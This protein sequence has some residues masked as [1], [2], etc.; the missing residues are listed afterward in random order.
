VKTWMRGAWLLALL[1]LATLVGACGSSGDSS[2]TT[3]GSSSA[4]SAESTGVAGSL[5]D[6]PRDTERLCGDK[7]Y[8][9]AHVDGFGGNSWRKI[10]RAELVDELRACPNVTVDYT[11]AGGDIQ[12]YNTAINSYVARGY[13]AI[14]TF[15]DFGPQALPALRKAYRA[16]VVV[17][18]YNAETGGKPG[19]DYTAEVRYDK[20][21]VGKQWADWLN[22][23]LNERGGILFMGGIPGNLGSQTLMDNTTKHLASGIRWLQDKPVDTN[24]DPAQYQ[25]VTTGLMSKFP[26]IDGYVSD[27]GAAEVG[28]MRAYQ[29]AGEPMPPLATLASSNELGCL[30]LANKDRWPRFDMLWLE[31][32]TR[33]V[34][35]AARRAL[36]ELNDIELDDPTT[37][38]KLYPVVDTTAG[39]EPRCERD[40]PP[41][42]DLSAGLTPEELKQL[43]N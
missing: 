36:A 33:L 3:S 8:R 41:D 30:Y 37:N 5:E 1:A 20:D 21:D 14:L 17:I 18:P 35:W 42:A 9:F 4:P 28:Q 22:E 27:Y 26:Q 12:K 15:D 23:L 34:R 32:T 38:Y 13:D 29:N 6:L 11:Q 43:F 16:G 7:P 24:W 40:L 39:R 31:G 10:S 19:V 25:R 2:G